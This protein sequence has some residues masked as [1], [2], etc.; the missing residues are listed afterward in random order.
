MKSLFEEMGG[1][2]YR[3]GDYLLPNMEL[4]AQKDGRSLGKYGWMRIRFLKEH[5][6]RVV[7]RTV[8]FR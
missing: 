2:Y 7:Y 5:R 1:T 8:A 3:E 4:P 6:Q